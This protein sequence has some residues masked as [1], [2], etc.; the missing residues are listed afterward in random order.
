MP[1]RIDVAATAAGL[2]LA[3]AAMTQTSAA[4]QEIGSACTPPGETALDLRRGNNDTDLPR[5]GGSFELVYV[6]PNEA[7]S[8]GTRT[9]QPFLTIGFT[10]LGG[11]PIP[12]SLLPGQPAGCFLEATHDVVIAMA[13]DPNGRSTY[14][15]SHTLHIP[16]DPSLDGGAFVVQWFALDV[17]CGFVPPCSPHWIAATEGGV[18][19]IGS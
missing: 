16:N 12:S 9:V 19:I 10:P 2:V 13:P 5:L 6:G 3:T 11:V 15:N 8:G 14:E 17:Q 18:A 1:R 7:P 4:F